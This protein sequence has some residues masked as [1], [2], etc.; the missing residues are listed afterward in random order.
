M[1]LRLFSGWEFVKKR[2]CN[3][4]RMKFEDGFAQRFQILRFD[5]A[6]R[7]DWRTAKF[8]NYTPALFVVKRRIARFIDQEICVG[9]LRLFHGCLSGGIFFFFLGTHFVNVLGGNALFG[10]ERIVFI[11]LRNRSNA[12][13][14]SIIS[15]CRFILL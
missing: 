15:A 7:E 8:T 6:K 2:I 4:F 12:S 13:G 5:E 1:R 14:P 9:V 10:T 3:N 11:A